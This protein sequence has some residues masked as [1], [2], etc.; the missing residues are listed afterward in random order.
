MY[1]GKPLGTVWA[2]M[3]YYYNT[4]Y[5]FPAVYKNNNNGYLYNP[6]KH[7]NLDLDGW[8]K[9]GELINY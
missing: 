1:D 9:M 5:F 3:I 4:F 6:L 8:W 7:R 2:K